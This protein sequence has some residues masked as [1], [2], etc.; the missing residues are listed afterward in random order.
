MKFQEL[1][2]W[3]CPGG[4]LLA[5]L[6]GELLKIGIPAGTAEDRARLRSAGQADSLRFLLPLLVLLSPMFWF[7]KIQQPWLSM[8]MFLLG[9]LGVF[10]LWYTGTGVLI[11]TTAASLSGEGRS[12][13]ISR[14]ISSAGASLCLFWAGL[15]IALMAAALLLTGSFSTGPI[16]A[17][18]LGMVLT[19]GFLRVR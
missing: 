12:P 16:P 2:P 18:L 7:L 19:A 17:L 11:R 13:G 1:L 4:A 14:F 5:V 15:F 6:C 3:L 9:G 10:L 8:M